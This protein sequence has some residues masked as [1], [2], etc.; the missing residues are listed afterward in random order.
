MSFVVSIVLKNWSKIELYEPLL[1]LVS[2][3]I[4]TLVTLSVPWVYTIN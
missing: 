1:V 3:Y 2:L 4:L